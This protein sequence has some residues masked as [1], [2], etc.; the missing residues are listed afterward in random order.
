MEKQIETR[1]QFVQALSELM[2]SRPLEKVKVAHL[3]DYVGVSRATFYSYF[4]DIFEVP[5]WYW[6]YLM[7]QSLYR[8]GVD[9]DCYQAHLKKFELLQGNKEFFEN[10]FKCM[11][12]NSVCEHGGRSVKKHALAMVEKNAGRPLT[13]QELLEYEFYNT[14][15]QYMTRSWVR[16]D[17]LQSPEIMAK[18]FVKFIPDFI[19]EYLKPRP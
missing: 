1:L 5:A 10:A 19:Q 18:L 7:D 13:E 15:A 9:M 14:G 3:C 16:G 4:Q 2:K 11:S 6:D 12:Y 17:M 8:Q